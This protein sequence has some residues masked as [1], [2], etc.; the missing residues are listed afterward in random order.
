M[1]LYGRIRF[2]DVNL[3]VVFKHLGPKE[4][5]HSLRASR[6]RGKNCHARFRKVKQ[7]QHESDDP[8]AFE[9]FPCFL[10]PAAAKKASA[11]VMPL[12]CGARVFDTSA[13]AILPSTRI[14]MPIFSWAQVN[15]LS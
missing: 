14:F 15:T 12:A 2:G 3:V 10:M 9:L 8:F 6:E 5:P 11:V 4:N 7:A 13:P 1:L